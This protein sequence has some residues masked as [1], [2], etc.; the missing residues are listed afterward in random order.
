MSIPTDYPGFSQKTEA[1]IGS[2]R[3][4]II[5]WDVDLLPE[6]WKY[7]FSL[8]EDV[9]YKLFLLPPIN[10]QQNM[11]GFSLYPSA[12]CFT[13]KTIYNV[14]R[15]S[16]SNFTIKMYHDDIPFKYRTTITGQHQLYTGPC[17]RMLM[18]FEYGPWMLFARSYKNGKLYD[19]HMIYQLNTLCFRMN[20]VVYTI[21]YL[22]LTCI[23]NNTLISENHKIISRHCIEAYAARIRTLQLT[24]LLSEIIGADLAHNNYIASIKFRM[25]D[26][27]MIT[28]DPS[29]RD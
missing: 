28:Y 1:E 29:I 22:A 9:E 19:W 4:R 17:G 27:V 25:D 6:I 20:Q 11:L 12:L 15:G 10:R 2:C 5:Y 18:Q 3:Q 21:Q 26:L 7:I 23:Y 13:N 24:P 8:L 14:L 16:C